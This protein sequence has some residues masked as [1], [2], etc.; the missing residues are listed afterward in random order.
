MFFHRRDVGV[1]IAR[2]GTVRTNKFATPLAAG[3][4]FVGSGYPLNQSFNSRVM[5]LGAGF[6][7]SIEVPRADQ[8]LYWLGDSVSGAT[9]Y[10]TD[11]LLDG[12][13]PYQYWTSAD[14]SNI[15]SR[16]ALKVFG[17][18]RAAFH[19]TATGVPGFVVP[20]QWSVAP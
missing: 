12:G 9:G 3:S 15:L 13:A 14:D 16:N 20:A 5:T 2:S 10:N 18:T 6:H 17:G 7:G 19:K 11:W 1:T 4:T 8:I